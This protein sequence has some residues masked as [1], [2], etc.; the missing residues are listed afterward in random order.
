M[1]L[2]WGG[3]RGLECGT[4]VETETGGFECRMGGRD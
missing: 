2:G 1:P 4:E 3:E